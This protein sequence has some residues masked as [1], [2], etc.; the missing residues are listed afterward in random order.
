MIL[1]GEARTRPTI[2]F[3]GGA[4]PGPTVATRSTATSLTGEHRRDE[5]LSPRIVAREA[6]KILA[7]RGVDVRPP[8]LRRLVTRFIRD[9][10]TTVAN[11]EP[12]VLSYVDPTGETAVHNV[13]R[14]RP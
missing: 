10:H 3:A 14:K 11:L 2:R 8:T 13:M 5:F 9:G 12:W 6:A 7:A 1:G 4:P